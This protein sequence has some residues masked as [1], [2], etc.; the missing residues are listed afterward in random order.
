MLRAVAVVALWHWIGGYL[1][2]VGYAFG[3]SDVVYLVQPMASLVPHPLVSSSLSSD[4][5]FKLNGNNMDISVKMI[6][7][8]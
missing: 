2:I 4:C 3:S 8:I 1:W 5:V 6:V 7:L